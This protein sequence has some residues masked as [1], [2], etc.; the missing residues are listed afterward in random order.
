M[1]LSLPGAGG[2]SGA[3]M[4]FSGAK[5]VVIGASAHVIAVRPVSS[6]REYGSVK[7]GE[8]TTDV[9]PICPSE[10]IAAVRGAMQAT[11]ADNDTRKVFA[12]GGKTLVVN[13]SCRFFKEKPLIGKEARLD[14]LVT[15]QDG[16]S[17]Q[18]VGVLYIEG[19]STSLRAHGKN[20][21][22]KKDAQELIEYLADR[23]QGKKEK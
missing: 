10:L 11:F 3:G 6:I 13:A 18:E 14:L 15:L 8:V 12:G 4:A 19:L 2:C 1:G 7:L 9:G 20:D 5:A 16:Q 17:Q 21:L 23:K 22:A